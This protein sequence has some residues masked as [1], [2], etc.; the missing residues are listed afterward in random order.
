MC[1]VVLER[2]GPEDKNVGVVRFGR[3]AGV[4]EKIGLVCAGPKS[5]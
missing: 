2:G 3:D 5:R 4:G 1:G